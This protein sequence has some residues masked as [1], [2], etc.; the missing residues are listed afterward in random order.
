MKFKQNDAVCVTPNDSDMWEFS[1]KIKGYD[2][3]KK[4]YQVI[5]QEENVWD[6]E[7]SELELDAE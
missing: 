5:D 2:K 7:E 6:F 1:G 4:M 3:R